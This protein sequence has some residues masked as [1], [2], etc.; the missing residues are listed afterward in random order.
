MANIQGFSN[1][2]QA[3]GFQFMKQTDMDIAIRCNAE[4]KHRLVTIDSSS[5]ENQ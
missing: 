5:C 4:C 2:M 1:R 3:Q